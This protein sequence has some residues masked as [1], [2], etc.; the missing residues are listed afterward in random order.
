M[1]KSSSVLFGLGSVVVD[2]VE[3]DTDQ[4]RTVH[5]STAESW[6]GI[7]P[8]CQVRSRRSKGWVTTRPRDVRIGPDRPRLGW[9]K[10]KWV[11]TNG[12]CEWKS[13]TE[14][15]AD[16]PARC[17]VSA[18]AKSEMALAV[19]DDDRSVQAV[20]AAYGCT[21]N[22]CHAAVVTVA[23]PVLAVPLRPVRVL[24][25][26]ETRRGKAKWEICAVTGAR[27]WVDRF[28][29]GLVDIT[30]SQGLLGQ[31]NGRTS[32]N[33]A[34]WLEQQDQAWRDGIEF[35]TIDMSAAYAKA[36]REAL[37]RAQIVVDRFH[38]IQLANTMVDQVRQ[39]VTRDGR[40][41]RGRKAD[42]EWQIRRRV[43][44]GKESL[45]ELELA[46]LL[47]KLLDRD[48]AGDLAAAWVAKELLRDVFAC[49]DT[50][51]LTYEI[52]GALERF[53]R[54]AAA[55]AAPEILALARTVDHWQD[56]IIAG[57][58]FNLSNGK[59]EGTNR[60]VKH[61]G[62][63]AFGFRNPA[64]QRRRV[65]WACT[66]QDRRASSRTKQLRPC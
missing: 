43:L 54:F 20:A 40:G 19:L 60:I 13:F 39:R 35:V 52:R 5:L 66:R 8:N 30:G 45:T 34:D 44:R 18:R 11:C 33:V 22:I 49:K 1:S 63:I 58:R 65:R 3:I 46:A 32:K 27:L 42:P 61:V 50:G 56:A 53:Y 62:R 48:V 26:D 64:N 25:I 29:T 24:G 59:S 21:W 7:C 55:G 47:D 23:E 2:R 9:A 14:A 41:R 15:T 12:S 10:R 6:V 4:V 17:R 36:A 57:I 31:V 28:D 51:G 16:F 38:V 37:P